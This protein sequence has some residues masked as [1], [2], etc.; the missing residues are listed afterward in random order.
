MSMKTIQLI[1]PPDERLNAC[2]SG[3][4]EYR[5]RLSASPE[6]QPDIA[7][8]LLSAALDEQMLRNTVR[9]LNRRRIPFAAIAFELSEETEAMLLDCGITQIFRLPIS[10]MLLRKRIGAMTA[11]DDR[12]TS[13]AG[14]IVFAGLNA[15]EQQRGAFVVQEADFAGIY[16]FVLRLQERLDKPAQLVRFRFR[17]QLDLPLEPGAPA[18]ALPLVQKCLRR[19][20]IVCVYGHQI[21]AILLGSDPNGAKIAAERIVSTYQ[22][23]CRD[24]F[25]DMQYEISEITPD[26]T[27]EV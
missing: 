17:A 8:V 19:G 1:S 24:S 4:P 16:Q 7:F 9:L 10:P 2:F 14:R 3:I 22:A 11:E 18:D 15:D 6:I 27:P 21:Y 13:D 23:Y 20:D 26:G 25:C 5:F 12:R